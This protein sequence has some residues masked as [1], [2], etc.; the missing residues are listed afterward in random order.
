MYI[1]K[2]TD[3]NNIYEKVKDNN[4]VTKEAQKFISDT[5]THIYLY[6]GD[7]KIRLN[8]VVLMSDKEVSGFSF[9]VISISIIQ[10]PP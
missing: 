1:N 3:Y 6:I 2:I 7:G 5:H 10:I 4:K 8:R 9:S